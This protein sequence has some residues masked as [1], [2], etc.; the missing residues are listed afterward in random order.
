M[1]IARAARVIPPRRRLFVPLLVSLISLTACVIEQETVDEDAPSSA[2]EPAG[3]ASCGLHS[4]CPTGTLCQFASG[5]CGAEGGLCVPAIQPAAVGSS[6]PCGSAPICGCD[7]QTYA[8]DC[9]AWE[10]GVSA[11]YEGS[12]GD[13]PPPQDPPPATQT[14]ATCGG[15]VCGAHQFCYLADG[16]CGAN[17]VTEGVCTDP[18]GVCTGSASAVCGCD[19]NTYPNSCKAIGAGVSVA[20]LGSC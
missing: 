1:Q 13:E 4:D 8:N 9:A 12:C 5:S 7:G 17:A 2:D 15:V 14:S 11:W 16:S 6:S 19:G 10:S 3:A 18:N 20:H